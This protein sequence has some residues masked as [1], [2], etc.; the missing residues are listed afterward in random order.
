MMRNEPLLKY[1]RRLLRPRRWL[2]NAAL[3]FLHA[4]GIREKG[5]VLYYCSVEIA[6]FVGFRPKVAAD[7]M[8]RLN[9]MEIHFSPTL[10]DLLI[11]REIFVR[12]VYQ[13]RADFR[14]EGNAIVFDIG[15]NIGLFTLQASALLS[16]GKIFAFEPNPDARRL[17]TRNV[18]EN[19][20][21]GVS[22]SP[23]ALG[24][25]PG[26]VTLSLGSR[27]G[28]ARIVG[29]AEEVPGER[30]EVE[31]V[32]L[33][34]VVKERGLS[35]IDLM[36]IDVEGFEYEVLLGGRDAM[37]ITRRIVVEYDHPELREAIRRFLGGFGFDLVLDYTA[38]AYFVKGGAAPQSGVESA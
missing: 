32:T 16:G 2:R 15:A 25:K 14:P 24:S 13:R 29:E 36:K 31:V 33:D 26:R 23:V 38:H 10:L 30:I 4:D 18:E 9:G 5:R 6:R 11:Y 21:K 19:R 34:G 3:Y 1:L 20:L 35:R 7:W 12:R 28:L 27:S 17:F 22:L 8:I 37:R